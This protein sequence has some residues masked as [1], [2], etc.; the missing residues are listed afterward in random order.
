MWDFLDYE[1]IPIYGVELILK[2]GVEV[3]KYSVHIS[4]KNGSDMQ[5]ETD[6]NVNSAEPQYI[7]G[8]QFIITENEYVINVLQV[9]EMNVV[10]LN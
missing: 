8:G 3:K 7:N 4:F 2:G 9:K 6:T 5:F 10:Q 1:G